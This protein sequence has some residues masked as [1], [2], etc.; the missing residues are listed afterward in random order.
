MHELVYRLHYKMR[1][2][3]NYFLFHTVY[4]MIYPEIK[5]NQYIQALSYS[6][7]ILDW[8]RTGSKQGIV[9]KSD[10]LTTNSIVFDVGGEIGNWSI[11]VYEKYKPNL[12]IFEPNP[13][14]IKTLKEKFSDKKIRI[15]GYG[16]GSKNTITSLSDSGMGSSI[17]E[18]SPAYN[19]SGKFQIEIRDIT[20]VFSELKLDSVDLI[21]INIE[22]GEYDLLPRIIESGI[23]N[24][25]KIIRVQFHDWIPNSFTMRKNIVGELAKTHN[26]EWSYPMVWES[27]IRKDLVN[28]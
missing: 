18:S 21:K 16:L 26:I 27:W 14:S 23:V 19:G 6:K 13:V 17:Y 20:E 1:R 7:A 8:S 5:N 25:C 15:L 2:I 11:K 12:Y 4:R 3:I 24:K 10:L 22:G 9:V 28:D